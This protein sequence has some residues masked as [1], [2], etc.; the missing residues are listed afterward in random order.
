MAFIV[1]NSIELMQGVISLMF[2]ATE[3]ISIFEH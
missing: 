2:L 1:Y 3:K